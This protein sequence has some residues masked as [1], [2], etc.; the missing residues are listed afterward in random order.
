MTK[1]KTKKSR[2]AIEAIDNNL[3]FSR[4]EAWAYYK[5]PGDNYE[6]LEDN[7]REALARRISNALEALITRG[8]KPVDC[9][10]IVT[11]RPLDTTAWRKQLELRAE[12]WNPAPGFGD[13]MERMEQFLIESG[14]QEK[15]VYLAVLLGK[16]GGVDQGNGMAAA[17]ESLT[18]LINKVLGLEDQDLSEQE[19]EKWRRIAKD[20]TR[21]LSVGNLKAVPATAGQIARLVKQTVY[22]AMYVPSVSIHERERWGRGELLALTESFIENNKKMLKITQTDL[23]GQDVEGYKATLCFSR[24]P[25]TMHF[26]QEEPWIHYAALL[27]WGVN[28]YSRFSI[29]PAGKVKKDV[30]KKLQETKDEL[31]NATSAGGAIPLDI[32]EKMQVAQQLEYSLTR[33]KESWIYGMHRIIVEAPTEEILRD[34]V[35]ETIDHYRNLGIEVSWP[36]GDQFDLLLESQPADR[37]RVRSYEQRQSLSAISGGMPTANSAVGDRIENNKG[38]IGPFIGRTTS[39]IEEPI[40]LSIHSAIARNNPPGVLIT[41]SPGGGKSF[42]A[43]TLTCQMAMQ[44]VWSIY[45]DPKADALPIVNIPGL[46]DTKIFDLRNGADG[47]LDPFSISTGE[48][49]ESTLMAMETIRLLMG[50]RLT[51]AQESAMIDSI[52]YVAEQP[53]PSLSMVVDHLLVS[54]NEHARVLGK[55]LNLIRKLKFAKLCFSPQGNVNINPEKGLTVITMLGLDLPTTEQDPSSYS[56]PNRLAVAI[57]YLLSTFTL[58]LMGS[59]NKSHPKAVIIDE[60]WAI[61]STQQGKAMIPKIAR[62]GRSLNTALMLVS[63]NA[64]DFTSEGLVNSMSIKMAFRAKSNDEVDGVI[65]LFDLPETDY[66]QEVIR[67]LHNGECLIQDTDG[68][69]ARVQIDAWDPIWKKAFDTNP[70][71]RGGT[72][73]AA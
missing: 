73:N 3:A 34:K 44:G 43:F 59:L 62:M 1:V 65:K 14:Y 13:Y 32:Q 31:K 56:F 8:D 24:F 10:L 58:N 6:F 70:E 21:T 19:L 7:A 36:S 66:H 71:T 57:M 11:S 4:T 5:L 29:V 45:I 69:T 30:H 61:T 22:P 72:G 63:Q 67:T 42:T 15:E 68:R 41:G 28:F 40:F 55:N 46:G 49:G 17:M 38:W 16:R 26:P 12:R 25:D 18:G 33:S 64:N 39:R 53:E 35:Q 47:L 9:H 51:S 2:L 27:G 23:N 50:S 54:E 20:Y 37:I 60:A 48:A 52:E